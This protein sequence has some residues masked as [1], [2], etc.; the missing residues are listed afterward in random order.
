MTSSFTVQN[1]NSVLP[2]QLSAREK[3]TVSVN[4][5]LVVG[6]PIAITPPDQIELNVASKLKL[7]VTQVTKL[8]TKKPG[9]QIE[10]G[11]T[12]IEKKSWFGS[13]KVISHVNGTIVN[14][15]LGIVT[16]Q[17][18]KPEQII[19]SP[20][21]G[22]VT[23]IE[24]Q[25]IYIQTESESINC[26]Q[27]IGSVAW[28]ELLILGNIQGPITIEDIKGNLVN[29]IA[30]ISGEISKANWHKLVALGAEGLICNQLPSVVEETL[31]EQ[32]SEQFISTNPCVAVIQSDKK[33]AIAQTSW[34]WFN[35]RVGRIVILNSREKKISICQ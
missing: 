2:F 6:D 1:D 21:S 13:K 18:G 24:N 26:S 31:P 10:K 15:N 3:I 34:E 20:V 7:K 30:V 17:T 19:N 12:L 4:D 33:N 35:N 5:A 28:G 23:K 27:V 29:K 9:E 14:E 32:L 22:T 16:I 8:M 25:T 11:E